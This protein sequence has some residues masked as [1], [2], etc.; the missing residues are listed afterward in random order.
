LIEDF[1]DLSGIQLDALK[2]IGNIG[3]GNAATAL[4]VMTQARIDMSVPQV[5]IMPFN[6]VAD[7]VGGP[8]NPVV[9]VYFQVTGSANCNMMFIL[10]IE[11]A[12]LLADLLMGLPPGQGKSLGA[13]EMSAVAE[14][15]NII[16]GTYLNALAM[17]TQMT[18]IP[19]VPA[20]GVDMA[21]A[22]LDG[23]LARYGEIGD[24]VLVLENMFKKGDLDVIGHLFLIPE[25]GA[26]DS[27]LTALGVNY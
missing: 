21:G 20:V 16:S 9:G 18:L 11:K 4:A 14:A 6:K 15:G 7:L 17:F 27:I 8:D 26:L 3:A 12:V 1:R 22:L 24:Y 23:V 25:P 5:G 2:E 10:S 13:M 19:S